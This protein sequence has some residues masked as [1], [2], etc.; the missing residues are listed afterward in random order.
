MA[1]SASNLKS[2]VVRIAELLLSASLCILI[3]L[4][5]RFRITGFAQ[6]FVLEAV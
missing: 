6:E 4:Q 5:R 2:S 1:G 3:T